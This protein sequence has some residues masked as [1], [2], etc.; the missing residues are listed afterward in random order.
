MLQ[1]DAAPPAARPTPPT[2][3]PTVP[4]VGFDLDMTLVDSSEGIGATLR[5]ALGEFGVDVPPAAVDPFAGLPLEMIVAGVAPGTPPDVVAAAAARYKELY[6][7]LG[8]ASVRAFPGAAR[9]LAAPAAHGGRGVV[10]S[11]KHTPNVHRVLAAAGLDAGLDPR[12]VAGDLFGD[13][14]GPFLAAAGATGYV[15]NHPGDVAAEP[16]AGAVAVGV[17]TGAHD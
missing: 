9:A 14:K 8:V 10:V 15:G 1:P 13:A 3:P 4:V 11:A 6:P 17:T 2:A 5:A 12:D 16:V 7:A